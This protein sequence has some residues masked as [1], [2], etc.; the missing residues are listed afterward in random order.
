MSGEIEYH[1]NGRTYQMKPETACCLR[2]TNP[3]CIAS[4]SP[5]PYNPRYHEHR[6]RNPT[7]NLCRHPARKRVGTP[8]QNYHP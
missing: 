5:P 2:P 3:D 4:S 1:V 7:G 8:F 6:C